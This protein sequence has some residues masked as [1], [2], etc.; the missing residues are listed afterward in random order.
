MSDIDDIENWIER[1]INNE[2]PPN[3]IEIKEI[4]ICNNINNNIN[5][6]ISTNDNNKNNINDEMRNALDEMLLDD[7]IDNATVNS[8]NIDEEEAVDDDGDAHIEVIDPDSTPDEIFQH[9]TTTTST[10]ISQKTNS[11]SSLIQ[12]FATAFSPIANK[13]RSRNRNRP[14]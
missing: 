10:E 3:I 4:T 9:Q 1:Y 13:L 8:N 14:S 6:Q 7:K 2:T 12:T 11:Q 5:S